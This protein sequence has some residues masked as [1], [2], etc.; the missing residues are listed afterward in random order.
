MR[1]IFLILLGFLLVESTCSECALSPKGIEYRLDFNKI[2]AG[3]LHP[4]LAGQ[5]EYCGGINISK[6]KS[7]RWTEIY[8]TETKRCNEYGCYIVVFEKLYKEND[9]NITRD[10]EYE[11]CMIYSMDDI[12]SKTERKELHSVYIILGVCGGVFVMCVII[13]MCVLMRKICL[14][15]NQQYHPLEGDTII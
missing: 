8:K 10:S 9:A 14:L 5:L 3:D 4:N 7:E 6:C 15:R 13:C 2:G 1:A 12:L 11:S